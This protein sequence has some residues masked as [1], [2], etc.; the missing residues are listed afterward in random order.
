M[1]LHTKPCYS[2]NSAIPALSH[3]L[4][5][6][7]SKF[8]SAHCRKKAVTANCHDRPYSVYVT[9]CITLPSR[10]IARKALSQFKIRRRRSTIIHYS[11]FI[12]HHSLFIFSPRRFTIVRKPQTFPKAEFES[13]HFR[14][15]GGHS[16]PPWPPHIKLSLS[17]APPFC[18]RPQTANISKGGIYS[19]FQPLTL[20]SV[21]IWYG[22]SASL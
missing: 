10:I 14:K 1:A 7:N 4:I 21:Q 17:I 13:A 22:Y 18:R 8:E 2:V 3:S 20:R 9:F 19:G 5:L 6:M 15:K 11:S 16:K 12:I